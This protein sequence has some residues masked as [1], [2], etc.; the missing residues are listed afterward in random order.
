[1]S[2]RKGGLWVCNNYLTGG[3]VAVLG[4]DGVRQDVR[5]DGQEGFFPGEIA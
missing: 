4:S 2:K 3:E 5:A 1:M